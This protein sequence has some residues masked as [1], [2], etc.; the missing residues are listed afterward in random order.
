MFNKE[1]MLSKIVQ[2]GDFNTIQY[3][4]QSSFFVSIFTVWL[5]TLI[6]FLLLAFLP[7]K[8]N[9]WIAFVVAM[10]INLL[11]SILIILGVLPS[12]LTFPQFSIT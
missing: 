12:L 11:G 6:T 8:T 10:I 7:K 9:L 4:S 3:I 1:L 5:V 2:F